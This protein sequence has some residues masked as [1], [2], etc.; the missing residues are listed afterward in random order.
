MG[1]AILCI[2]KGIRRKVGFLINSM[3]FE[4][5]EHLECRDGLTFKGLWTERIVRKA[6]DELVN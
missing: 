3:M 4:T 2:A 1:K 5:Q 6:L